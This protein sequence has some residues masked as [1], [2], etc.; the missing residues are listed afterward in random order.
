MNTNKTVPTR[1]IWFA[2]AALLAAP[3]ALAPCSVAQSQD[4]S[5]QSVAEAARKAKERKKA[6]PKEGR[7]ITED[8]LS[9]RPASAD[10][11]GAPPAGTVVTTNTGGAAET[12]APAAADAKS[13]ASKTGDATKDKSAAS[14]G[15]KEKQRQVAEATKAKELLAEAQAAVDLLK[16]KLALD[17]DSFYSNPEHA[18]D[19]DGKAKL[20]ELKGLISE[21]QLSVDDLKNKLD[22]LMQKAGL[23]P[24]DLKNAAPPQQ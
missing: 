7:V 22:D 18:R 9:L 23:S 15:A 12:A 13:E 19:A 17:S 6:A 2:L 24:D 14:D 8:T 11:S 21:K 1:F 20:D 4:D 10:A 16:R 3:F 5:S